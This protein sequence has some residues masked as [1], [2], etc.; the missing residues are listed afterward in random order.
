MSAEIAATLRD[1]VSARRSF[2]VMAVPRLAG[3]TTVTRAMLAELPRR[4]PVR[5]IGIDGDDID[6]LLAEA[7]GGYIVIPEIAEGPW[8]PG[9]IRGAPVRRIFRGVGRGV[10]LATALHAPDPESAF[11]IICRDNAVP[12]ADAA[13]ISLVVYLRSLGTDWREPERR[14]VATIHAIDGVRDGVPQ[15]RLLHRWNG[16]ARRFETVA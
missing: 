10:S 8:A 4:T 2:L 3:K 1:A 5:A 14:V 16:R 7:A 6:T 9:Y 11:E 15:A 12:D 13:K